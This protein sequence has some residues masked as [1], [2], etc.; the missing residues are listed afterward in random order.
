[1]IINS[2]NLK[3]VFTGYKG[4]FM[5]GLG[6]APSDH[7]SFVTTASSTTG[8]EEYGWLGEMPGMRKWVGD[9]VL[10]NLK[11]YGYTIRNEDFEGTV[12]V[13]RNAIEDDRHGVY[14]TPMRALGRAAGAHPCE[15]SYAALSA[16]FTRIGYDGKPL[17]A[18]DHPVL[19]VNGSETAVSNLQAGAGPAWFLI[20]SGALVRPIILQT[21]QDTRFRA[22]DNPEDPNVFMRKTFIYG[23]EARR[24]AAPGL[25]QGV[26][27]SKAPLTP[28]NY[29]AARA[30]IMT[31]KGDHGRPLGL[32]PDLLLVGGS[33][34]GAARAVVR[35]EL[36]VAGETNTWAGTARIQVSPWLNA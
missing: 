30:A 29:A 27:A 26:F 17:F 4:A 16:G 2:P 35:N 7:G 11:E 34:E 23:A 19:D 24:A 6:Q 9:R 31:L 3:T 18:T 25:W 20:A 1:V 13:P 33:N 22:L 10:N 14:A 12:Q 21:R 15:L 8:E 36:G 32:M 5:E 28:A